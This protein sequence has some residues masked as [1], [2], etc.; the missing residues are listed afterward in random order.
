M[1]ARGLGFSGS[2]L[3]RLVFLIGK[4]L[5]LTD[6]KVLHVTEEKIPLPGLMPLVEIEL[7]R[8]ALF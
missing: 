2:N 5:E 4:V 8:E 1:N 7:S 3:A 6:A